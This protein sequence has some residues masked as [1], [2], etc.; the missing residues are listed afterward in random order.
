MPPNQC[1]PCHPRHSRCHSV[2]EREGSVPQNLP[3]QE[4]QSELHPGSG[5]PAG[6]PAKASWK[7]QEALLWG[8]QLVSQGL[9]GVGRQK[10]GTVGVA[11]LGGQQ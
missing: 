3:R 10:L 6:S 7:I 11:G 9:C 5:I 1:L 8:L 2:G 4:T